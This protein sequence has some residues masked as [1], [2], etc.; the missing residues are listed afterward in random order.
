MSTRHN[1]VLTPTQRIG[2]FAHSL[3]LQDVPG[4]V[5]TKLKTT[6]LHGLQDR[7][8]HPRVSWQFVDELLVRD[9]E[10]PVE[11]LLKIGDHRL[12]GPEH[13]DT[14]RRLVIDGREGRD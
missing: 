1:K 4:E 3:K 5:I 13:L 14:F 11:L 2:E 10:Y 12:S 7:T 8:I 6:L 9:P